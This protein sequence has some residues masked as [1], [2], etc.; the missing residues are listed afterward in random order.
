MSPIDYH[1]KTCAFYQ[2]LPL[3]CYGRTRQIFKYFFRFHLF[4]Y[5]FV[6]FRERERWGKENTDVGEK[7]ASCTDPVGDL[8]CNPGMCP[9]QELNW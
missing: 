2:G 8:A 4:I 1:F 7:V 9:D 3:K 6:Y 5:L